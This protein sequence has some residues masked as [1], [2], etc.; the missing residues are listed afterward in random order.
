MV[1]R[2]FVTTAELFWEGTDLPHAALLA[3]VRV[4]SVHHCSVLKLELVSRP[5]VAV[6]LFVEVLTHLQTWNGIEYS[7][8]EQGI[9]LRHLSAASPKHYAVI[10]FVSTYSGRVAEFLEGFTLWE[11][12][13]LVLDVLHSVRSVQHIV[14]PRRDVSIR[15]I[16]KAILSVGQEGGGTC[17]H[18]HF[19]AVCIVLECCGNGDVEE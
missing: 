15:R 11:L 3:D 5:C 18:H 13:R 19:T 6:G 9:N 4:A 2:E 17:T 16:L 10:Y 8:E 1:G 14:F 12:A 7:G